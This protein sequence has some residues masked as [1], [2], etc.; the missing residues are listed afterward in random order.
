MLDDKCYNIGKLEN[1]QALGLN[2]N[3]LTNIPKEI[4]QLRNLTMLD[5]RYN[6][7]RHSRS[8]SDSL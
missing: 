7:S 3:A 8:P 4:G 2:E 6:R 5:M 1:L